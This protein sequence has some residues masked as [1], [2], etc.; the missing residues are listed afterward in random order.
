MRGFL[1]C[2][3]KTTPLFWGTGL[4]FLLFSLTRKLGGVT[5]RYPLT[6]DGSFLFPM[7]YGYYRRVSRRWLVYECFSAFLNG[8]YAV[9]SNYSPPEIHDNAFLEHKLPLI[10]DYY[11]IIHVMI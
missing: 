2:R 3:A 5:K 9:F 7:L 1:Y 6:D 10:H 8:E 11:V 4:L